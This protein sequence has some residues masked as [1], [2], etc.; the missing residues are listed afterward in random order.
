M[1]IDNDVL[2]WYRQQGGSYLSRMNSV[3]RSFMEQASDRPAPTTERQI[4]NTGAGKMTPTVDSEVIK[5]SLEPTKR[6][7]IAAARN[8]SLR[9]TAV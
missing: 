6:T 2:E 9:K 7:A 8:Q 4:V 5:P 3:L 1:R